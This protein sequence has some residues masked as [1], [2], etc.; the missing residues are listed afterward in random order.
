MCFVLA[1][2]ITSSYVD[3]E[4]GGRYI[5]QQLLSCTLNRFFY[6]VLQRYSK[7]IYNLSQRCTF[8]ITDR[9]EDPQKTV[10]NWASLCDGHDGENDVT[11]G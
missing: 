7:S 6:P 2:E 3:C 11:T 9:V 5:R 4:W 10:E 1:I 8:H